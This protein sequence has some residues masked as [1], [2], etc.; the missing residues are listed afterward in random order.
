MREARETL[1]RT[2]GELRIVT[3][4]PLQGGATRWR[5]SEEKA[6]KPG[7]SDQKRD[8]VWTRQRAMSTSL[9]ATINFLRTA[10]VREQKVGF[11]MIGFPIRNLG[12]CNR[13]FRT[14]KNFI[15]K[16]FQRK[17]SGTF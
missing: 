3:E 7:G 9:S 5:E 2:E 1:Q 17:F 11:F 8:L 16:R 14:I 4:G 15:R 12:D 10:G 13:L 6:E